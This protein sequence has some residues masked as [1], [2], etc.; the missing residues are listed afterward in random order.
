MSFELTASAIAEANRPWLEALREDFEQLGLRLA[1][2]ASTSGAW[3]S[4][5][6][7]SA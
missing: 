5:P 3:W 4:A 6:D 1:R 7:A 2:R